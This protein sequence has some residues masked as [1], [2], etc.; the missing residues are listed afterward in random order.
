[1]NK[2]LCPTSIRVYGNKIDSTNVFF[3]FIYLLVYIETLCN[4][5]LIHTYFLLPVFKW[6]YQNL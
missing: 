2:S 5:K 4:V 1:M 6:R 3:L